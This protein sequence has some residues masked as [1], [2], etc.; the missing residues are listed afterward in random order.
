MSAKIAGYVSCMGL[1]LLILLG[2]CTVTKAQKKYRLEIK[3]IDK[4]TGGIT[5][6]ST[7]KTKFDSKLEVQNY[8]QV[9]PETLAIKGFIAA[10][11]DSVFYGDSVAHISLYLG[12][13][14]TNGW[15]RINGKDD[16]LIRQAFNQKQI[17]GGKIGFENYPKFQEQL[18]DYLENNGYPFARI[19]LDSISLQ[20]NEIN[21]AI[22][23]DKGIIYKIDSIRTFG[24]TK[25]SN[26][27]LHRHLN[28]ERG[29]LYKKSKLDQV[30]VRLLELPYLQ[31]VQPWN[32]TML[33]T[34]AIVNLYLKQKQSNQIS[35]LAGFLPSNTQTGGKLLLTVDA[36]VQLQ[37]ALGSGERIGVIWQQIQPRSPRL[38]LQFLQPFLFNTPIG[39]EFQFELYKRDSAFLNI[40][41][42]IGLPYKLSDNGSAKIVVQTSRSNILS[43]DTFAV[44][45]QKV[46]PEV[47]DVSSLN[48]GFEYNY[49]KTNYRQNPR[50]G[51]ELNLLLSAGRKKIRKNNAIEQIRDP[52]FNY[53]ALYDSINLNTY[54]IQFQT[55]AAHYFPVGKQSVLKANVTAGLY[56]SPN[57]YKN[58]LFQIGGYK[59]LRGFDEESIYTSK[60]IVSTLEYRYLLSLNSYF[61]GFADVGFSQDKSIK[62][63]ASYNYLSSGLGLSFETKGGLFNVSFAVGKRNDLQLNVRQSKIHL[64]Y[65]SLF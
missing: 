28:L 8:L 41:A 35:V 14:F 1:M 23:I 43:T 53:N 54:Q 49:Y 19:S 27:V 30:N 9:V 10:S 21:A 48:L 57:F 59:L 37:N 12:P 33:N 51:S 52:A 45:S 63:T 4:D 3:V 13:R 24:K 44:K 18:L 5:A 26:N 36:N 62:P 58:D 60:Y 11:V 55:K 40:D 65:V 15:L 22:K 50:S 64:G 25:I 42:S 20:G 56:E 32:L 46:L 7:I 17:E 2:C 47:A 34:G 31:Q 39:A 38:N 16:W 29:S 61:F 6:G